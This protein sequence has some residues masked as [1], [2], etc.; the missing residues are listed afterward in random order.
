MRISSF[1]IRADCH[2]LNVCPPLQIHT[3]KPEE[4]GRGWGP[5]DGA[6]ALVRRDHRALALVPCEVVRSSIYNPVH[7]LPAPDTASALILDF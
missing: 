1:F 4:V 3:V 5:H 7:E 2:G 6:G